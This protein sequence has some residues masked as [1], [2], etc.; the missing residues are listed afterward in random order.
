MQGVRQE[1]K[2]GDGFRESTTGAPTREL[3]TAEELAKALKVSKATVR[4][5]QRQGAPHV[6]LGRLRRYVLAEVIEWHRERHLLRRQRRGS[7]AA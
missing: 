4:L 1:T 2:L 3:L 7:H 6:P 5:W